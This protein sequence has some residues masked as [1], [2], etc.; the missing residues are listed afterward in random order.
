MNWN[1][2]Y[3]F[4]LIFGD[5]TN[6]QAPWNNKIWK[7]NVHLRIDFLLKHSSFYKKTGLGTIQYVPKPNSQYFETLKLGKLTWNE[8][9]HEKWTI[10]TLDSQRQFHRM[11]IWTPSRGTCAKLGSAPDIFFSISNERSTYNMEHVEFEWFAVLAVAVDIPCDINNIVLDLSQSMLAKKTVYRERAWLQPIQQA[12]WQF[13]NGIQDTVSYGIYTEG[14]HNI[15]KTPFR[16]L[17][18][19]PFWETIWEA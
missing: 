15:H 5:S 19:V 8:S 1:R 12:P 7:E 11:D 13:I 3:H 4:F 14:P 16:N 2:N 18:F 9:S 6:D 17:Q 10:T